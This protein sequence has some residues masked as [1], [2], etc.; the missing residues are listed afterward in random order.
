METLTDLNYN[1]KINAVEMALVYFSADWCAPCKILGPMLDQIM[2]DSNIAFYKV[3]ID[4]STSITNEFKIRGVPTILVFKNGK[5][6]KSCIGLVS[7]E[8]ILELFEG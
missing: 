6:H 5:L 7:K 2:K 8:K 3:N 4:D 1:E